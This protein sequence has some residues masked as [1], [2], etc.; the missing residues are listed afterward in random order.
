M[1]E[2]HRQVTSLC[3]DSLCRDSLCRDSPC[4]DSYT[5]GCILPKRAQPKDEHSVIQHDVHHYVPPSTI[6]IPMKIYPPCKVCN[7]KASGFH[8]GIM[9]C[10]ACKVL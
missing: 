3:R 7:G 6:V 10:E 4:R 5:T 9:T 1:T 2:S 8:F